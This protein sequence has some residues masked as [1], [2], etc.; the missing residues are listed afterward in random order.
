MGH[1]FDPGLVPFVEIDLEIFS[2]VS[3]LLQLIQEGLVSVTRENM[4]T[5]YWLIA[6]IVK[7]AW[8]KCGKVN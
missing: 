4:C 7:I 3:L 5:K 6:L 2:M 1:E 8:K